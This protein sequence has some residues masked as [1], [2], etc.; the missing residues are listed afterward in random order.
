MR[1]LSGNEHYYFVG[2][3]VIIITPDA[4]KNLQYF[5]GNIKGFRKQIVLTQQY[6]NNAL[7][8]RMTRAELISRRIISSEILTNSVEVTRIT[9]NLTARIR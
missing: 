4:N 6:T 9:Q 8:P 3:R 2:K 1:V 5:L 7:M